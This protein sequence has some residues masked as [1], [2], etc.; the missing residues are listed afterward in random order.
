MRSPNRTETRTEKLIDAERI[1]PFEA[2]AET[3]EPRRRDWSA[4]KNSFGV[5]SNENTSDE[6]TAAFG[7]GLRARQDRPMAEV[8]AVEDADSHG[9]GSGWLP[10]ASEASFR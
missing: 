9:A 7:F 2:L 8:Q 10:V 6:P 4:Q 5:G 1:E 3:R